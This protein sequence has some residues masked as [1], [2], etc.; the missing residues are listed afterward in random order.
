M[1]V[2][3]LRRRVPLLCR[4]SRCSLALV[5]IFALGRGLFAL[6]GVTIILHSVDIVEGCELKRILKGF[7]GLIT[8]LT[9]FG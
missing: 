5:P 3:G 2:A 8:G 6:D 1:R 9:L 4:V 7:H